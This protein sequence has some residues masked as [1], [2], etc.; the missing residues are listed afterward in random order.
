MCLVTIML[1]A[2]CADSGAKAP[3]FVF[4]YAENQPEDYPTTQ[5]AYRFAEMVEDQTG[6][7]IKII[8]QAGGV[9]GDEK[10]IIEQLQFGGVDFTRVSLSPLSEF[11][12]KL[13]VLQLP[14]LYRDKA[15]MWSVLDGP[16][17]EDFLNA[18]DGSNMV[19]LSWYG[20]GARNFYNSVR[21]IKKLEDI[22]GL[23]I[24]VQESDMMMSMVEAL[25][26]D[27]VPM[28]YGEVYKA[29]QTG[30]ID[31]AENNWPSYESTS[32]FEVA[33]YY[34]VDE[35]NRVPELQLVSK[36]TWNQLPPEDQ[37]IIQ[38]CA[39]ESAKIERALWTAREQKSETKVRNG[40]SQIS[41]LPPEEKA[42]FQEAVLP[43][44]E[45]YCGEYMDIVDSIIATGK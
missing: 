3:E 22:E 35:H 8:I 19:A 18:F 32:H 10:S 43:M 44:Y 40:G 33:K 23:K 39:R 21:P 45:R 12:P 29:L 4:T 9:L 30:G 13:N 7:R 38:E 37:K 31:G 36:A 24:R 17:G 20:A 11:V 34:T 27:P 2:G 28:A 26:A 16:I 25:G 42:R 14:Y 5:A 6:G 41:V 1:F 15:H